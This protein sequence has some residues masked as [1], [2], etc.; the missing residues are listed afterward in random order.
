MCGRFA[1]Y[2]MAYEYLDKIGVQLPLL[3]GAASDTPH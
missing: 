1:Q 2:R 3:G